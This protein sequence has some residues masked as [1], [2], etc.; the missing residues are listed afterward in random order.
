MI[1]TMDRIGERVE[2]DEA[3]VRRRLGRVYRLLI[4]A[5][6][7]KRLRDE[8]SAAAQDASADT[9]GFV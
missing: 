1:D 3:E 7:Q 2:Y 8:R 5:A 4:E 6:R 9:E